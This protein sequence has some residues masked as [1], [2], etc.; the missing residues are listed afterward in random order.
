MNCETCI[1]L[2]W[3]GSVCFT[4]QSTN[5]ASAPHC[6]AGTCAVI[7]W[8]KNTCLT[9]LEDNFLLPHVACRTSVC[10]LVPCFFQ[11]HVT[12]IL[13]GSQIINSNHRV[14]STV[15]TCLSFKWVFSWSNTFWKLPCHES[16]LKLQ[17]LHLYAIYF[18]TSSGFFPDSL[19]A[20]TSFDVFSFL[21]LNF[22]KILSNMIH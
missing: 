5:D 21:P 11:E 10:H 8:D 15:W 17:F 14:V 13:T 2:R 20:L 16:H 22:A 18:C 1:V 7:S 6:G 12:A 4:A 19:N 9:S 3:W